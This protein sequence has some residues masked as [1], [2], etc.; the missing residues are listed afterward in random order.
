MSDLPLSAD[1]VNQILNPTKKEHFTDK[2][3]GETV[4]LEL[5][6]FVTVIVNNDNECVQL[7]HEYPESEHVSEFTKQHKA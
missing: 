7:E 3:E 4:Y 5:S 6:D 2:K 1:L